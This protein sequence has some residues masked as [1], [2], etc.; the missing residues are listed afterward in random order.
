MM[1]DAAYYD[2]YKAMKPGMREN[3]AVALVSQE[4]YELGSEYVEAVNAI[5]GNAAI[6]IRTC[7]RTA[8]SGLAIRSTTTSS[9]PTWAIAPA[10]T[11]H[12]RSARRHAPWSTP[13]NGAVIISTPRLN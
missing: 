11:G 1:V 9:T 5:S 13:T 12:S 6:R 4:L 8:C 3:D 2:L 7:F 10:T